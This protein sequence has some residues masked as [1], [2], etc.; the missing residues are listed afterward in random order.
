MNKIL[1][2]KT[3]AWG[4]FS[5][6]NF[7]L[8]YWTA[9]FGH[10]WD[11]VQS[12]SLLAR[13]WNMRNSNFEVICCPL[14]PVYFYVPLEIWWGGW[15]NNLFSLHHTLWYTEAHMITWCS[16]WFDWYAIWMLDWVCPFHLILYLYVYIVLFCLLNY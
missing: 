2:F 15:E 11:P 6:L 14:Y 7:D 10:K 1:N 9:N 4:I 16:N 13:K 12:H 8:L 3:K 5:I